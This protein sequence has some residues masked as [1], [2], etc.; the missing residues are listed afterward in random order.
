LGHRATNVEHLASSIASPISPLLLAITF[1]GIVSLLA[2]IAVDFGL[3]VAAAHVFASS[4]APPPP[5]SHAVAT[6]FSAMRRGATNLSSLACL[7]IA[8]RFFIAHL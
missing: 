1:L 5:F 3:L 7:T 8:S 4:F 2:D 6:I